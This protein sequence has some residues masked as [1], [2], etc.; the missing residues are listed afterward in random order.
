MSLCG[1]KSIFDFSVD[2]FFLNIKSRY[3]FTELIIKQVGFKNPKI[4]II[5]T[6]SDFNASTLATGGKK[7]HP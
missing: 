6:I 2:C 3:K 4:R 1:F 7:N 5:T